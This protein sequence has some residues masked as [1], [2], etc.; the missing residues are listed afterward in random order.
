MS[1][2]LYYDVRNAVL[3]NIFQV[4][5]ISIPIYLIF[6]L[7]NKSICK[8]TYVKKYMY[9]VEFALIGYI[10]SVLIITEVFSSNLFNATFKLTPNLIPL[11]TTLTDLIQYPG[12][13]LFQVTLNMI[14]FI[15]FGFI[16]MF[17]SINEYKLIK[18]LSSTFIFSS[19]VELAQYFSG[20]YADIDDVIWNALGALVG[21]IIFKLLQKVFK[22]KFSKTNFQV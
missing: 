2:G 8:K 10:I 19:I 7:I 15:P 13:V 1:L 16:L 21:I 9:I 5:V 6:L 20:R 22:S 17:F 3:D 4:L 11:I 14:F 18:I 12:S